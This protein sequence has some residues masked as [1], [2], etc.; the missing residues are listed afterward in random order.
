MNLDFYFGD[1]MYIRALLSS[2]SFF[3]MVFFY[4]SE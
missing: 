1:I 4:L 3:H 2:F